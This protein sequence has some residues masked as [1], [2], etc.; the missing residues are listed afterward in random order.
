MGSVL[1]FMCYVNLQR[2]TGC[3]FS[4]RVGFTHFLLSR[5]LFVTAGKL[6]L[7]ASLLNRED[8]QAQQSKVTTFCLVH[9][10]NPERGH[11]I[12]KC[13]ID[14]L[15]FTPPT[16]KN[17]FF[18]CMFQVSDLGSTETSNIHAACQLVL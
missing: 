2:D 15:D 5:T 6:R 12:S 18:T 1:H 13:V 14:C 9:L 3:C 17:N 16:K 7:T 10:N 8:T 11:S 4:S